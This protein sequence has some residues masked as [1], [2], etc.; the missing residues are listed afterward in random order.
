[1]FESFRDNHIIKYN[2]LKQ[3][4]FN[5]KCI[6]NYFYGEYSS[7]GRTTVCG[8]VRSLFKS[9]Y[10]PYINIE[11]KAKIVQLVRTL[12]SCI[13]NENS[14]FSLGILSTFYKVI[15]VMRCNIY[16]VFLYKIYKSI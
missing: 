6:L 2:R 10:S 1:M 16:L 15:L 9:G 13:N 5:I 11:A 7:I 14:T 3:Y 4:I 12:I 8:T